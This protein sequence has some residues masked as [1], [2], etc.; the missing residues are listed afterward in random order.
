MLLRGIIF[1]LFLYAGC[2]PT[3]EAV[4]CTDGYR[5][6]QGGCVLDTP[7][8]PPTL[9]FQ[10]TPSLVTEPPEPRIGLI[11]TNQS[12]TQ[13]GA[14]LTNT[15]RD[16]DVMKAALEQ[17]GFKVSIVRDTVNEAALLKAIGD[18]AH[19]LA[20][21][22]PTAVGFFYYSG[23]GA[24]DR[25]NGENYLIPTGAPVER[26]SDLP[27]MGVRLESIIT[28]LASAGRMSFVVLDA[29]RNVPLLRTDK[30]IFKGFAP[31]GAQS[32]LLLAFATEPGNVATDQSLY[33]RALAEELVKPGL[34]ATQVFRRVRARIRGETKQGQS[35]ET[36]DRRDVDFYFAQVRP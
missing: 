34:E 26:A 15:H 24:A 31:V 30:V 23:H 3:A 25:P 2:V 11:I 27:L 18:H 7:I 22:G 20:Q 5:P 9:L 28:A 12:Y 21:A 17:V 14:Q 6:D 16:G 1:A 8:A 35:P 32:G 10:A 36:I 13:P 19:R 29:C 4:I 33:A